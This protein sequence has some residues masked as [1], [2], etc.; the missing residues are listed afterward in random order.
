MYLERRASDVIGKGIITSLP[1]DLA[2]RSQLDT[3]DTHPSLSKPNLPS[4]R[5]ENYVHTTLG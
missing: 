5:R 4:K 3:P 1:Q 2:Q